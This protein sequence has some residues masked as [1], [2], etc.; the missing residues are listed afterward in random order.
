[1]EEVMDSGNL[2]G[3]SLFLRSPPICFMLCLA[4]AQVVSQRRRLQMQINVLQPQADGVEALRAQVAELQACAGSGAPLDGQLCMDN[5]Q[6]ACMQWI[7]NRPSSRG[8]ERCVDTLGHVLDMG[9]M[10]GKSGVWRW[11]QP[12]WECGQLLP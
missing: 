2:E 11:H 5:R 10:P 8:V 1:M 7:A 9:W 3:S 6:G 12:G 4:C